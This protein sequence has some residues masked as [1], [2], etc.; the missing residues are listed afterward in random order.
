MQGVLLFTPIFDHWPNMNIFKRLAIKLYSLS[1]FRK[2]IKPWGFIRVFSEMKTFPL[3][4]ESIRGAVD[5]GVIATHRGNLDETVEFAK[6][7]CAKNPGFIFFEYP[8]KV[9]PSGNR[10]YGANPPYERTLAA[11]YDAVLQCIP[12]GAWLVKLDADQIYDATLLKEAFRL[13]KS[14]YD[15][16]DIPRLNVALKDGTPVGLSYVNPGD[17]WI[18][19]KT[20]DM[21]FKNIVE[22]TETSFYAYELLVA[23]ELRA[24]TSQA[25]TIHFP[26]EKTWRSLPTDMPTYPLETIINQ[27]PESEYSDFESKENVE[28]VCQRIIEFNK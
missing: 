3:M 20:K 10:E 13:I 26:F 18:L 14:P 8:H 19:R 6:E 21:Y 15:R 24:L 4:L 23:K 2:P 5:R 27:I 9:I 12:N 22:E 11:Y 17:Q 7:F 16:V 1:E 28:R 25:L